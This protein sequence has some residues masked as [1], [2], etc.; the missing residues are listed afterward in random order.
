MAGGANA[1]RRRPCGDAGHY[2]EQTLLELAGLKSVREV[3]IIAHSMG[4]WL[5]VETQRQA[6]MKGHGDLQG[7]LG[8]VVLA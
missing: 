1:A 4:N 7:K 8:D 5:A 6:K 3:N 2:L